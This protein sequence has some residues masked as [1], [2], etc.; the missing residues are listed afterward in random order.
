MAGVCVVDIAVAGVLDDVA[1]VVRHTGRPVATVVSDHFAG[2]GVAVGI[3]RQRL[4]GPHGCPG[5]GHVHRGRVC[6][7]RLQRPDQAF[8]ILLGKDGLL[9]ELV[10][11]RVGKEVAAGCEVGSPGDGAVANHSVLRG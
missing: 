6:L 3:K 2:G 11:Q 9:V 7:W 5:Q 10:V 8:S 1:L 4:V